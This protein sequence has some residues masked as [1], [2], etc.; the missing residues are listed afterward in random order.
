MSKIIC[1]LFGIPQITKDGQSVFMPYVKMSA[2]LFYMLVNK[3]VSRTEMAGLLWPEEDDQVARKN[4]RNA[5]YRLHQELGEEIILSPKKSVLLLNEAVDLEV[6]TEQFNCAPK[7]HLDLYCGIFLQGFSLKNA[8]DYENWIMYMRGFYEKKFVTGCC[9]K[10]EMDLQQERYDTIEDDIHRLISIDEYDERGFRLLMRYYQKTGRNSKAIETYNDFSRMLHRELG[11]DPD[12]ETKEIY[13]QSLNLMKLDEGINDSKEETFFYGRYHELALLQRTL[14]DFKEKK[15]GKAVI[16]SGELGTGKEIFR[17]RIVEDAGPDMLVIEVPCFQE[18]R[19]LL[20]RPWNRLSNQIWQRLLQMDPGELPEKWEEVLR[21]GMLNYCEYLP[22]TGT[23]RIQKQG[24]ITA[25][26]KCIHIAAKALELISQ[27]RQVLLIFDNIQWMDEE[28]FRAL[29]SVLFEADPLRIT[30]FATSSKEYNRGAE[31]FMT[32]LQHRRRLTHIALERFDFQ[33]CY[34]YIKESLPEEKLAGNTVERIYHETEGNPF[35]LR[36]QLEMI[37]EEKKEILSPAML[38]K[39]KENFLYLSDTEMEVLRVASLFYGKA[40]GSQMLCLLDCSE[41]E[42]DSAVSELKRRYILKEEEVDGCRSFSFTHIKLREYCEQS[43][44]QEK[45]RMNHRKLGELLES[46]GNEQSRSAKL[47]SELAFHFG[48][49]GE[50]YKTFKYRLELLKRNLNVSHEMF[51]TLNRSDILPE[52]ATYMPR[53]QIE[54]QFQAL[55]DQI[56]VLNTLGIDPEEIDELNIDFFYLRGRHYIREGAYEKGL[57]DIEYVIERAQR[58]RK[59]KYTLEGYKQM[60]LCYLQTDDNKNMKKFVELAMELAGRGNDLGE[61]AICC[62]L[63]GLCCMMTGGYVQAEKLFR[64][65]I[66]MLTVTDELAELHAANIAAAY[67]YLGEIE[68]AKGRNQAALELFDKAISLCVKENV[69]SSLS[70]FYIDAG[71]AA[72]EMGDTAAAK[73][74]FDRA[75]ALYGEFDSFW[76]RP[77]LEAYMAL[78]LIEEKQYNKAKQALIS[79]QEGVGFIKSP[80]DLGMVCC[81]K[82]IARRKMEDDM[83]LSRMLSRLLREEADIY[84]EQAKEHLNIYMDACEL[85][86]LKNFWHKN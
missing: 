84:Y 76:R 39:L 27:E 8:G 56:D 65:S 73:N 20:L 50:H 54:E 40:V 42:F 47:C 46:T 58:R 14:Q 59:W 64:N 38:E 15:A 51:P 5:I 1:K 3:K 66:D 45:R 48:E 4:L 33:V 80:S 49:A 26:S 36:E 13:N 55:E 28:S 62:R 22:E 7:D 37:R 9:E 11:I 53:A 2:F 34:H 85:R 10:I 74:Y 72:Y 61:V 35:F 29:T 81:A 68:L 83:R 57:N 60:S 30:L 70:P 23:E 75:A 43:Q 25:L 17:D 77:V 31:D 21:D 18:E 79:A 24:G 52:Q 69:S 12:E 41:D 86:L 82:S 44:P 78:I 19:R 71:R 63:K 16:I 32:A 67:D 6:D